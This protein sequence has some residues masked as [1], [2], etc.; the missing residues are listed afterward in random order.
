MELAGELNSKVFNRF[1]DLLAL[2]NEIT[3]KKLTDLKNQCEN[4]L[5]TLIESEMNTVFTNDAKYLSARDDLLAV[6]MMRVRKAPK[7]MKTPR[8]CSL[9]R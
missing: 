5:D 2:I 6:K 4:I 7:T 1:P 3:N 9:R 8:S